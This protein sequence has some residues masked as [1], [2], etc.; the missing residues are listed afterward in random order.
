MKGPLDILDPIFAAN[1]GV[2]SLQT[3]AASGYSVWLV[4]LL[5]VLAFL[6]G[7]YFSA[8]IHKLGGNP[9]TAEL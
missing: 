4:L 1:C 9:T 8:S 3:Q 5:A 6:A 2:E 7:K